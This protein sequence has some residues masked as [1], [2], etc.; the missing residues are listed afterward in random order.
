[1]PK[2]LNNWTFRDV[3]A[4]LKEHNFQVN[5][6]RGSHYYYCGRIAGKLRQVCVPRHG[7]Q[8]SFAPKTLKSIIA[9]SGLPKSLWHIN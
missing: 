9:Q 3:E 5:H 4:V 8:L 1:M 6:I 7:N 2:G